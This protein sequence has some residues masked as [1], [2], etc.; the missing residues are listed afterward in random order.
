[1]TLAKAIITTLSYSNHFH[2]PLTMDELHVRLVGQKVVKNKLESEAKAL[3]KSKAIETKAGFYFLPNQSILVK[4]RL[5]YDKLSKPLKDLAMSYVPILRRIPSVMAIYLTGSLAMNNTDGHD[6]IDLLVIAR[7]GLLWTTR[8]LL[9]MYTSLLGLRRTPKTTNIMGKL[10]LNLYLTPDSYLMPASRR[11]L[12]TAYELLQ[13]TPLY[14]PNN[15]HAELLSSNSWIKTYLPNYPLP[16]TKT[17]KVSGTR[18]PIYERLA[19]SLQY[20]YMK[21]RITREYITRD[22]AFFHPR[23]PAPKV[24]LLRL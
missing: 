24:R 5:L 21:P 15:T 16:I 1:M 8:L 17:H 6:D 3:I 11:S 2:Y 14:D 9:T 18:Y 20:L 4:Q 12:Y 10:C 19:Y 22:A 7:P 13:M 23:N